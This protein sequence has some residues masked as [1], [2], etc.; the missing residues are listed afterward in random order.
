MNS[1]Y[2]QSPSRIWSLLFWL[3]MVSMHAHGGA[4]P[5]VAVP[6]ETLQELRKRESP[7]KSTRIEILVPILVPITVAAILFFLGFILVGIRRREKARIA[8]QM[9]ADPSPM[10]KEPNARIGDIREPEQQSM[11]LFTHATSPPLATV[12]AGDHIGDDVST[13][14]AS[15]ER[16]LPSSGTLIDIDRRLEPL[17]P[18]PSSTRA[19][20]PLSALASSYQGRMSGPHDDIDTP[21]DATLVHNRSF[22]DPTPRF[23][24]PLP[25]LPT[26]S[27][28]PQIVQRSNIGTTNVQQL[29]EDREFEERLLHFIAQRIDPPG[30]RTGRRMGRGNISESGSSELPPSYPQSE[31]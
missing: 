18:P 10:T 9:E 17:R 7:A 21:S 30:G 14:R 13:E 15:T 1:Y 29:F 27:P 23:I 8:E 12:D 28:Q 31:A 26:V 22:E 5:E 4:V 2:K 19:Q 6:S 11:G 25:Q 24:R 20:Y 3:V 16:L